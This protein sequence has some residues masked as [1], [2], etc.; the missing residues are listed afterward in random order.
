MRIALTGASGLI[1]SAVV[2]ALAAHRHH[3]VRLVRGES[4]GESGGDAGAVPWDPAH[5]R[6][7]ARTLGGIDAVI[8]LGGVPVDHRW[9]TPYKAAI[10]ASRVDST[11]LLARTLSALRPTPRVFIVA[12][13]VG[14]YGDR[15]DEVLDDRS[16]SGSGFLAEVGRAWEDAA[17][18][19]RDAGIRTVH[20]RFGF[21][22]SRT[23][24]ALARMLPAFELGAGGRIGPGTQWMSWI[25]LGD[26]VR[27]IQFALETPDLSGPINVTAPEPALNADFAKTLGR[28]LHRPAI[29]VIP[30]IALRLAFGELADAALLASQR[31]IPRTLQQSGFVFQF[32][33]LEGALQHALATRDA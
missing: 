18:P 3:V 13:A 8:H 10:R 9:T 33:A 32:P 14:I 27:A 7:D 6:L 22:L 21:V 17:A 16:A 23:G 25:E 2:P 15:G 30:A 31:V 1:G 29:A 26:V 19:A 28:V 12:S 4:G 24:G 5:G 20:T 11:A